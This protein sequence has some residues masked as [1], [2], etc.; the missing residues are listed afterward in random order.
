MLEPFDVSLPQITLLLTIFNC[1]HSLYLREERELREPG[2]CF[3]FFV[4]GYFRSWQTVV[5]K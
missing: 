5:K 1:S 2:R 3:N 4:Q